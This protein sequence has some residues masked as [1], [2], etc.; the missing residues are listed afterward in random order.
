M[1]ILTFFVGILLIPVCFAVTRTVVSLVHTITPLYS[2]TI[3]VSA[4]ALG[5]GFLFWIV[6]YFILPLPI[7][8]YVLAHELTHALWGTMMGARVFRMKVA[9]D[10]GSVT[11]SKSNF[12]ITLAPYFF[13]LYTVIVITGYYILSIFYDVEAYHLF[14]LG[15]VG[16]TWGFHFTFTISTLLQHQSDINEYGAVFSYALIYL[17]NVVGICIWIVTVS[18][19]T[20]EQ[21]IRFA[22]VHMTETASAVWSFSLQAFE[23]LRKIVQ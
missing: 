18:S 5:G 13:P 21:M 11:M 15:L 2:T 14:W 1:R 6:L 12:L 7:R 19:A 4:W 23:E 17:M 9:K 8:T 3:P 16:F 20:I 10:N 22:G